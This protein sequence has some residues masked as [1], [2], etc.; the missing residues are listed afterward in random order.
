MKNKL[1]SRKPLRFFRLAE[2]LTISDQDLSLSHKGAG[3]GYGFSKP[4][5]PVNKKRHTSSS[6]KP[7]IIYSFCLF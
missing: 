5:P 6:I 1:R 4:T 7:L 2:A 3:F